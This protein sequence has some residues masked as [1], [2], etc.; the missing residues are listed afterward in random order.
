[1]IA[2]SDPASLL[3]SRGKIA[4]ISLT[5]IIANEE[6]S[7][8][9]RTLDSF[10]LIGSSGVCRMR[11][12]EPAKDGPTW[13]IIAMRGESVQESEPDVAGTTNEEDSENRS[14]CYSASGRSFFSAAGW[15]RAS[16]ERRGSAAPPV[17]ADPDLHGRRQGGGADPHGGPASGERI[18]P[19]SAGAISGGGRRSSS[20]PARS[21]R[22]CSEPVCLSICQRERSRG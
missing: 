7:H 5:R 16:R 20:A 21:R 1:M 19:A 18:A 3:N 10:S 13:F 6:R 22:A 2:P 17:A 4:P 14:W 12:T 8:E 9:L 11:A 15:R